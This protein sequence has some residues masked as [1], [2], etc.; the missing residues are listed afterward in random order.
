[1]ETIKLL[2]Y[3][4]RDRNVLTVTLSAH[5]RRHSTCVILNYAFEIHNS[6]NE[7]EHIIFMN[8]KDNAGS[9]GLYFRYYNLLYILLLLPM[10]L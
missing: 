4:L 6:Q 1:M 8:Y 5:Y 10:L 2:S 9:N 7:F 3:K